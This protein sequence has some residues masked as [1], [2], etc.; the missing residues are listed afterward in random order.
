MTG[1]VW[2]FRSRRG[3]WW[4]SRSI[5]QKD[6]LCI[7]KTV[8]ISPGWVTDTSVWPFV[9]LKLFQLP[10]RSCQ[11]NAVGSDRGEHHHYTSPSVQGRGEVFRSTRGVG[12][13]LT[14][15]SL[16]HW[17]SL[18]SG[19]QAT[20]K[21]SPQSER[22]KWWHV[23]HHTSH[24]ITSCPQD[25]R[26][27]WVSIEIHWEVQDVGSLLAGDDHS[28]RLASTDWV[29]RREKRRDSNKPPRWHQSTPFGIYWVLLPSNG[30]R[31]PF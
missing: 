11:I 31:W 23:I 2:V 16:G 24:N 20:T 10:P 5:R 15:L 14:F 30:L 9:W 8:G 27:E 19:H 6:W 18:S 28:S 12:K 4:D 7:K 21:E 22:I 26:L 29:W 25:Y 3:R 1:L 17:K 13:L